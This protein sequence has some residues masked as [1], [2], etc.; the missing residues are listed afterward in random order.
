MAYSRSGRILLIGT[1]IQNATPNH[2]GCAVFEVTDISTAQ[3]RRDSNG[4]AVRLAMIT[5]DDSTIGPGLCTYDPASSTGVIT[6]LHIQQSN[7]FDLS[8]SMRATGL[9]PDA[10][11]VGGIA[12]MPPA[13]VSRDAELERSN[14]GAGARPLVILVAVLTLAAVATAGSRL[15]TRRRGR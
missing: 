2:L 4:D 8:F 6:V 5:G 9:H 7:P 1:P 3:V 11:S 14:S 10:L 13:G 15:V 12:E